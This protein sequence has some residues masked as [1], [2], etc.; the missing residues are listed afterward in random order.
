MAGYWSLSKAAQKVMHTNLRSLKLIIIDEASMLSN[1]NLD[2]IHLRLK[3]LFGGS[4]DEYF[5]SMNMETFCNCL[6]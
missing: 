5:G 1:L 2:Y 6:Q 3:E 4:G